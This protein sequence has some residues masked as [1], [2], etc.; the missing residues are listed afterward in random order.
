[1]LG[2]PHLPGH[3]ARS[4]THTPCTP[5][6]FV[7]T[8][9]NHA[10]QTSACTCSFRPSIFLNTIQISSARLRLSGLPSQLMELS[11]SSIPPVCV[12]H[13]MTDDCNQMLCLCRLA[14]ILQSCKPGGCCLQ[15]LQHTAPTQATSKS[16]SLHGHCQVENKQYVIRSSLEVLGRE[17]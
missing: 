9:Q 15:R 8:N 12:V 16:Q 14:V 6:M 2:T 10:I 11:S 17:T 13:S 5:R 4:A 3:K 7:R 1:M